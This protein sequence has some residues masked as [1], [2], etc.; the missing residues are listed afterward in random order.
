MATIATDRASPMWGRTRMKPSFQKSRLALLCA[1]LFTPSIVFAED[2]KEKQQES[3]VEKIIVTGS[4]SGAPMR[5]VDASFAITS[6]SEKDIQKLAPKNTADLY[7]AVPGVWAETS[8]GV[9]NSNVFVRGFPST[10][11]APYL[12]IQ[13]QGAPIF[14]PPTLSFLDNTTLFRIDE[15]VSHMEALRGGS[16]PVISNGQPGLTTNFLL[17]EGSEET[18]GLVKYSTSDFGLQRVDAMVSGEISD[19]L[20]FMAGGYVKSSPGVRDPGF[21]AEKG[22]Q[23][24][25]N[26][27]KLLD[28]GKFNFYLRSTDDYGIWYLPTPLIDGVDNEYTQ[29]GPNNRQAVI[30]YGPGGASSQSFDFADGRGWDGFVS[31]GSLNLELSDGW[32]LNERFS[33]I[34]GKANTF[35]LVP[36]GNPTTIGDL[37]A[38]GQITGDA[39]GAVTGN[40]YADSTNV[41]QIGRWVVL[42]DIK[43]FTNDLSFTKQFDDVKIT[44]G[45]YVSSYEV[46]D[47]WSLGNHAYHVIATGGEVVNG[48]ACHSDPAGCGWN[49]D[50]DATGD[51]KT[52]AFYGAAE[53]KATEQL[54]VDLGLRTENHDIDYSVDEGLDGVITKTVNYDET[55]FSWTVGANYSINDTMGVFVRANDGSKMPYFDD[56]RDNYGAFQSGEKLI[57]QIT[58]YEFGYKYADQT[59][60]LYATLFFNEVEGDSFVARPGAPAEINTNEAKGIE[61]DASY[62]NGDGFSIA[63][64]A[65][66]QDTEITA[67]GA[68]A[69]IGKEAQRQPKWQVRFTPTY[70]MELA[71]SGWL[72]LYGTVFAVSDRWVDNANTQELP[73]YTKVDVGAIYEPSDN[74][75]FQL[76]VD[77]LTDKDGLTEGDPRNPTAPNG[78]F[79]LPRNIN[80]SVTYHF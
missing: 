57:R 13:L 3:E 11:D 45:N 75:Q 40:N 10:G 51:G 29:L 52:T 18:E 62:N 68:A 61:L 47:W 26:I 43:A 6:L 27:T 55:E 20:Y 16:N 48:I 37:R 19:D 7:R 42:K 22:R 38:D 15:T 76:S 34:D 71:E 77:N 4:L 69:T 5:K 59:F 24:T 32:S 64:N 79:I 33:M 60:G 23:F 67:S 28:N 2:S 44:A 70:E 58:Q 8:G 31:G 21:D 9:A 49:Y 1:A 36:E 41:Q 72:T 66:I 54:T 14:Q 12:T 30:N 63:M 80:L 39:L 46:Q 50:I 35:G 56:F 73:A 25:I 65:T 78:R 17:K 74:L 53:Y